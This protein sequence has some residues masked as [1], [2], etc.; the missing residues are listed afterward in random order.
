MVR[1]PTL[2]K[3]IIYQLKLMALLI[4]LMERWPIFAKTPSQYCSLR[5]YESN[6]LIQ[7]SVSVMYESWILPCAHCDYYP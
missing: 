7:Y 3:A 6:V 4:C 5:P 2:T 1:L